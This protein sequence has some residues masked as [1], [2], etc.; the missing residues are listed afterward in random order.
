[1]R[2]RLAEAVGEPDARVIVRTDSAIAELVGPLPLRAGDAGDWW[3]IGVEG[4]PHIHVRAAD[5]AALRLIAPLDGNV[6]LEAVDAAGARVVRVSFV[7]TNPAKGDCDRARRAAL[8]DRY[9]GAG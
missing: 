8:I 2:E 1:M 5:V 3:T 9:G 4:Q 7:R 6:A